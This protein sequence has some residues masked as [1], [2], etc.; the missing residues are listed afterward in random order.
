MKN[1]ALLPLMFIVLIGV[2]LSHLGLTSD[3][4]GV[5]ILIDNRPV[6]A[7]GILID[8]WTGITRNCSGVLKLS[9][10]DQEYL[11]T[12]QLIQ[13]YSPPSSGSARLFTVIKFQEWI[14]A[15]SEFDELLPAVVL[16]KMDNQNKESKLTIIPN[17]VWSGIT[18]PWKSAPYIRN[19]ISTQAPD[20]PKPLTAC[21]DPQSNSFK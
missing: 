12:K 16:I 6:D 15:E 7:K 21:F 14:L 11:K 3:E 13:N 8:T 19:Y 17:A 20:A 10:L 18:K 4:N 9:P 5:L 1:K 2:V